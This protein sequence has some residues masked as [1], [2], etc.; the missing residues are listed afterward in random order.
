MNKQIHIKNFILKNFYNHFNIKITKFN[1]ITININKIHITNILFFLKYNNNLKFTQLIDIY[2]TDYLHYKKQ[3]WN[4]K[5]NNFSKNKIK[6]KKNL[7]YDH[8]RFCITYNLLSIKNNCR[9][10]IH[11]N[12]NNHDININS[13]N[14]IFNNSNWNERE[15]YDLFGIIFTNH[16]NLKRILSDYNFNQ[17]ALRKDFPCCGEYEIYYDRQQEKITKKYIQKEYENETPKII[18]NIYY[19]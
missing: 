13:I 5:T 4:K 2:A 14:K 19:E 8:N 6:I 3:N 12:L 10:K 17:Y 9:I 16:P 18:N 15:I 11:C 7:L 1:E